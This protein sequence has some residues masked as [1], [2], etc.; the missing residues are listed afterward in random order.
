MGHI[1]RDIR[2]ITYTMYIHRKVAM[3][4]HGNAA[5]RATE[6]PT[7]LVRKNEKESWGMNRRMNDAQ[8]TN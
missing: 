1:H 8:L 2:E 3:G 7:H 5:F 6:F 4:S